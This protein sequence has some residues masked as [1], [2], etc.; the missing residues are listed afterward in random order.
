[1]ADLFISYSRV[2]AAFVRELAADLSARGRDVWMDVEDIRPVEEFMPT[3]RSAIEEAQAVAFVLSPDFVSS[4]VCRQELEHAALHNKKLVP[5]LRR[6]IP[7]DSIPPQLAALNWINARD[8][9]D[10]AH[11]IESLLSALDTDLAW[12]R[13]HTRL[14]VRAVEW[15]KAKREKSFLLTGTDLESAEQALARAPQKVMPEPTPL[16][17]EYVLASRRGATSRQRIVLTAVTLG[18]V[19]AAGLAWLAEVRRGQAERATEAER[20]ARLRGTARQLAAQ[21]ELVR[22]PLGEPL[23][24]SV[25]LA[26]ESLRHFWSVEGDQAMRRAMAL[27]PRPAVQA[28]ELETSTDSKLSPDGTHVALVSDEGTLQVYDVMAQRMVQ[29][30]PA[31]GATLLGWSPD[32]EMLLGLGED[33]VARAWLVADGTEQRLFTISERDPSA[34]A[35]SAGRQVIAVAEEG[36]E[37]NEAGPVHVW[38]MATRRHTMFTPSHSARALWLADD[39][40]RVVVMGSGFFASA[41][42]AWEPPFQKAIAQDRLNG[43]IEF[44]V[45]DPEGST[46]AFVNRVVHIGGGTSGTTD[47]LLHPLDGQ[48]AD[49]LRLPH[50][51]RIREVVGNSAG[52]SLA[53]L[54][55]DGIVRVWARDGRALGQVAAPSEVRSV[56]LSDEGEKLAFVDNEGVLHV[57]AD[58]GNTYVT[59]TNVTRRASI[60]FQPGGAQLTVLNEDGKLSV[61]ETEAGAELRTMRITGD[62]RE[63]RFSP[64]SARVVV[65]SGDEI[66]AF[67]VARSEPPVSLRGV[68]NALSMTFAPDGKQFLTVSSHGIRGG[69]GG[70]Q[71]IGDDDIRSWDIG[72]GREVWRRPRKEA[73][74]YAISR[75]GRFFATTDGDRVVLVSQ[76]ADGRE[77]ARLD[78]KLLESGVAAIVNPADKK[79]L[80]KVTALAFTHTGDRLAVLWN[81]RVAQVWNLATLKPGPPIVASGEVDFNGFDPGGKVIAASYRE[82]SFRIGLWEA[83]TA[84]EVKLVPSADVVVS[85]IV[86]SADGSLIA[87]AASDSV[88]RVW[89]ATTR[90]Q[91]IEMTQPAEVRAIDFS[92]DR[93]YLLTGGTDNTARVW[94]LKTGQELVRIVQDATVYQASFSPNGQYVVTSTSGN[95][96]RLWLWRRDDLIAEAGRRLSRNL[97]PNEWRQYLPDEQYQP[98]FSHLV[99]AS[100][101]DK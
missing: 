4:A 65:A 69:S 78:D 13:T 15:D 18:L 97:T 77:I 49:A 30:I 87:T 55:E 101:A 48:Q 56:I 16:Q 85:R 83:D 92:P 38:N 88:V 29:S 95:T 22:R 82:T 80:S 2:D 33:R 44:P 51:R 41:I 45:V 90:R 57:Y 35:F 21:S 68:G 36:E 9:D 60:A 59:S 94:N 8:T 73:Y 7:R 10:R 58:G 54:C 63:L 28:G 34:F 75:D 96:A 81:W 25:L 47:L 93:E 72:A 39:G 6:E 19:I 27:L 5:I 62:I 53:T 52:T 84:A 67:P 70:I 23:T 79:P 40:S 98:T 66:A 3:I 61:I 20:E 42:E 86:F 31:K 100:A 76:L 91:V 12:V 43:M 1:M 26:A 46:V 50:P 32:G 99:N 14:V 64:D 17:R 71:T 74:A 89:D 37:T 11:A 24:V